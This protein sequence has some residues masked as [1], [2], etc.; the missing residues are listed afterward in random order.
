M[1]LSY[2][3]LME[4]SRR[5]EATVMVNPA[6]TSSKDIK[7]IIRKVEV[8]AMGT[9]INKTKYTI[10]T[11]NESACSIIVPVPVLTDLTISIYK[12]II[13]NMIKISLDVSFHSAPE[14]RVSAKSSLGAEKFTPAKTTTKYSA[15]IMPNSGIYETNLIILNNELIS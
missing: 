2:P 14:G 5:A 1:A 10:N 12:V 13:P 4:K 9:S 15:R 7:V 3:G 6:I 8:P 11:T